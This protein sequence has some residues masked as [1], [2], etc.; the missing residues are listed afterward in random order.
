MRT[1][2][3]P[4]GLD[5]EARGQPA[6]RAAQDGIVVGGVQARGFDCRFRCRWRMTIVLRID[7]VDVSPVRQ[8]GA[9]VWSQREGGGR[10]ALRYG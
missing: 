6:F 9:T 3:S 1:W 8:F 4:Q 5:G 7:Q 10:D 2:H